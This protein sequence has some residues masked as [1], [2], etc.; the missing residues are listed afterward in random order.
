MDIEDNTVTLAAGGRVAGD[1]IVA[2]D[3]VMSTRKGKICTPE[4][5]KAQCTGEVAYRS[6]LPRDVL[7]SDEEL[8]VGTDL[9]ETSLRIPCEITSCSTLFSCIWITGKPKSHGRP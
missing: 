2:A 5:A 3:G 9:R 6:S 4:A 7:E 8:H 1:V